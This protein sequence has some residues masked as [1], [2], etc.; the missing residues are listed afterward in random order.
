MRLWWQNLLDR[1]D[2]MALRERVL[3][4]IALLGVIALIWDALLMQPIERSR[5]V[6]APQ[7]DNLRLELDRLNSSIAE[8]ATD[9]Q[10][11]PDATLRSELSRVQ[12]SVG[13]LENTLDTLTH[14]LIAPE[15]MVEVLRNVLARTPPLQL[16]R[17]ETLEPQALASLV[18]GEILPTQIYRHRVRVELQ[19]TYLE[20]L[21][22]LAKLEELPWQFYWD[23]LELSSEGHPQSRVTVTLG[24]LGREEAWIGV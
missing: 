1:F 11:D 24:T 8:A 6:L 2:A 20:V 15:E 22:F 7:V 12:Q 4:M 3:I 14:G 23:T 16:I 10:N 21:E 17:L 13:T 5:K 19:G 18:P 9:S